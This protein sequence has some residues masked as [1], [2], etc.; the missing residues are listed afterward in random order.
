MGA[1]QSEGAPGQEQ[2]APA[3]LRGAARRAN[4][5][6]A[7]RRTRSTFRRAR[8]SASSSIEVE[9]PAQGLRRETAVRRPQ[10]QPAAGRDRRHHR[11]ERR[12]QDDAV[13]HADR[14][15]EAGC[16]RDPHRARRC[17]SPTSTSRGSRSTTEDGLAGDLRRP[18]HDQGRQLRDALARLCRPVQLPRHA[19][20]A[21]DRRA[22]GR[23][24]Q[25]RAPR[26]GAEGAAATC[27]CSTSRPTTST[28]RRCARSKKR[29]SSFPGCAVVIS[30]DRWFLDRIA[31]HIL[32]FEGDS[33]VVWFEGNYSEYVADLQA[34]PRRRR[35]RS[36]TASGS[37]RCTAERS[38]A[39]RCRHWRRRWPCSGWW[40]GCSPPCAAGGVAR[41]RRSA[42]RCWPACCCGR[43]CLAVADWS[44][45]RA[46]TTALRD[47]QAVAEVYFE[48]LV[49]GRFRATMTRLPGG[50]MQVFDLD[51]D[52][53]RIDA[54]TLHWR[55]WALAAGLDAA[56]P[57]RPPDRPRRG[58]YKDKSLPRRTYE[59]GDAG[60][61]Q[62][63]QQHPGGS[64]LAPRRRGT[65]RLRPR[66]GDDQRR[67]LR[68][69]AFGAGTRCAADQRRGRR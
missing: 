13:P 37:G 30:H 4:S 57:A 23:R 15:G 59:L 10:L 63:W 41:S 49:P 45:D 54:R 14:P 19:A 28:S 47:G 20:A 44:R 18:G 60:G 1:R 16:R 11:P 5:R 62:F 38:R 39:A 55:G 34:P 31:T 50:R 64:L 40:P 42:M 35:R 58:G 32:A 67:A 21:V 48:Q 22:V 17:S 27:C 2:G 56:V 46:A 61:L 52:A 43:R 33:E 9:G 26:E 29:C 36:R 68:D 65:A 12:R 51:G 24:A 3:A 8:G 25:S 7:T 53:W 69:R 66:C 6:S